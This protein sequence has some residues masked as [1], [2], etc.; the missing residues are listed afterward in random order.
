MSTAKKASGLLPH[1]NK[2]GCFKL[3]RRL[4]FAL[5]SINAVHFFLILAKRF[6]RQGPLPL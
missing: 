6:I 3:Q 1:M 5:E 2:L 4:S